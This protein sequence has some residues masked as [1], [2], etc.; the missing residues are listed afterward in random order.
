M[1]LAPP[2]NYGKSLYNWEAMEQNHFQW[3]IQRFS[4]ML[5]IVDIIRVDHFIGFVNYWAVPAGEKNS[6]KRKLGTRSGQKSVRCRGTIIGEIAHHSG[7]FGSY[8]ATDCRIA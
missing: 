4:A 8:N 7:R 1:G 6:G 3:W 2:D 5:K